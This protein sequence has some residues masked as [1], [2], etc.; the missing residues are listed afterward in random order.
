MCSVAQ[1]YPTLWDPVDCSPSGSSVRGIFQA[2]ILEWVAISFFRGIF[3]TQESHPYCSCLLHWQMQ[4]LPLSHLGSSRIL[5]QIYYVYIFI[6]LF[7]KLW[8]HR[9]YC[10]SLFT[11]RK[12]RENDLF[13]DTQLPNGRGFRRGLRKSSPPWPFKSGLNVNVLRKEGINELGKWCWEKR[14]SW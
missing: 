13:K 12:L 9:L 4:P 10:Y 7:K 6:Y 1:S 3:L 14:I 8:K 2:R 5:W 11:M